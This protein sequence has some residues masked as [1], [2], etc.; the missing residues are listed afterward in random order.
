MTTNTSL[1]SLPQSGLTHVLNRRA[2]ALWSA[3]LGGLFIALHWNF[4]ERM[5][6]IAT[7]AQG[8]TGWLIIQDAF[9]TP[10]NRDWSHALVVPLIS[11]YYIYHNRAKLAV[12]PLRVFW[13]GLLILFIGMFSFVWWIFPGRNDFFQGYSMILNLFGLVLLLLGPAAMKILWFPIAYL[14]LAVKVPGLIWERVAFS[15]QMIAAQCATVALNVIGVFYGLDAT[16][17]GATIE[18]VYAGKASALN[19]AEACSGLRMLMAFI[20]LGVALAFLF[21]RTWWQRMIMVIITVPIAILVNI[22]RVTVLGILQPIN[23]EMAHGDFH[24]M[25]GLIMLVPAA[26]LFMFIGW[27]LDRILINEPDEHNAAVPRDVNRADVQVNQQK[28][29]VV[30]RNHL[31]TP[32]VWALGSILKGA[33]GGMLLAGLTG[34][35]YAMVLALLSPQTPQYLPGWIGHNHA[36]DIAAMVILVLLLAGA[37]AGVILL[38]RSNRGLAMGVGIGVLL[39]STLGLNSAVKVTKT[40]MRKKSI[41]LRV[42]LDRLSHNLG[43]WTLV[44]EEP[45]LSPEM[46]QEL[47]TKTYL[48]RI[49]KDTSMSIGE[50]AP[51]M[52]LHLTYYTG[53]ADTV[54]HIPERCFSGAGMIRAGRGKTELKLSGDH[55]IQRDDG[56]W[57][58]PSIYGPVRLPTNHFKAS[59]F[60]FHKPNQPNR[61]S[62]VIYFFSANGKYLSTP[63]HVRLQGFDPTDIYS[64][65]CKIELLIPDVSDWDKATERAEQ[66]LSLALPEIMVCLP[67]WHEVK[68][69]RLPEN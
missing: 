10:W 28:A 4:I 38:I 53:T 49:Y 3:L 39:A 56:S 7:D 52:R 19:I 65:Y 1:T 33:I 67:D 41:P 40:V 12:V 14:A 15:L 54:P 37:L 2:L 42:Q 35:N 5:L 55:L 21:D 26:L 61:K 13:P 8:Q 22:G 11:G 68:Q 57:A 63:Q 27:I 25:I 50:K 16:V 60:T 45:P 6:R 36:V 32:E 9:A 51:Y 69:G 31:F 48:S 34:L 29:T 17:S 44:S 18:L 66:F 30:N 58:A 62:N 24:T 59:I 47:G 20:S 64:Y 43:T 46:E 23:P